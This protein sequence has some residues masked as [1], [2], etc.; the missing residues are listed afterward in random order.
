MG[1][2]LGRIGVTISLPRLHWISSPNFSARSAP[3]DLIVVHDTQG[4]YTGAISWFS[5]KASNVSAHFVLREDG[6]E[7]VQMIHLDKKA[8]HCK[9]FNS[10]SIG[11]EMAG[12][13]EKGFADAEW[14]AE[15]VIVAWLLKEF[16]IPA[17]WAKGGVGPGFCTHHDLG[18]AGGGHVDPVAVGSD[19]W[20]QFVARVKAVPRDQLPPTWPFADI[21]RPALD[22][23]NL[24]D[25]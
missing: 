21:G 11:V 13:T 19:K 1:D 17:Q 5:Q 10:R 24:S 23:S 16:N 20:L 9:A 18:A 12:Y 6:A 8:W 15:A 7:A 25:D 22:H 2:L 3:V 4:G 14:Q